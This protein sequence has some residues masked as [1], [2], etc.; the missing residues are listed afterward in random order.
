MRVSRLTRAEKLPMHVVT[1]ENIEFDGG[2]ENRFDPSNGYKE[3]YLKIWKG[4]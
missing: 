2:P 4:E 1:T 3:E